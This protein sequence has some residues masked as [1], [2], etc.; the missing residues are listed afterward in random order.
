M[1][2][3]A[4]SSLV[5]YLEGRTPHHY[6]LRD[7]LDLTWKIKRRVKVE[8][9]EPGVARFWLDGAEIDLGNQPVFQLQAGPGG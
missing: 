3:V 7:G 5:I 6:K 8:M 1:L 4:E 9:A 2:A